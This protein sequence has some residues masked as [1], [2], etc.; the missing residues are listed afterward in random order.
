MLFKASNRGFLHIPA[1]GFNQDRV[2]KAVTVPIRISANSR[3][4]AAHQ[5]LAGHAKSPF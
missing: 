2:A 4:S 5:P 1:K 3:T